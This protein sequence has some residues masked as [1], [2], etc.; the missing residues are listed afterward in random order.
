MKPQTRQGTAGTFLGRGEEGHLACLA[1]H[2]RQKPSEGFSRG[3][4][5]IGHFDITSFHDFMFP[6]D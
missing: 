5:P 3:G 6:D 4:S 1:T 2:R